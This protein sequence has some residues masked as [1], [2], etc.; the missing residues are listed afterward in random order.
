M[1]KHW[2]AAV[3]TC[4]FTLGSM[5]QTSAGGSASGNASVTPGQTGASANAS[6][7]AQT[8][9]AS[10]NADASANAQAAHEK[11]AGKQGKKDKSSTSAAGS[12]SGSATAVAGDSSALL[13]SGSTLQAEL[14]KSVDAKKAKSG[15][16]VTA[17]LTQD[18]KSNGQVVLH[19]GSKLVGHVTEAQAK[20]KDNAESK[21][22]IVFDKAVGKGSQE[23]AFNGVIQALAPPAQG[24]LSVAGD[25]SGNLGGGMGSNSGGM[26]SGH[27]GGG[28]PL[29]GAAGGV[30]STAGSA[31]GTVNNTAGS[32]TN[33]TTGAVNGSVNNTLGAA[34]NG[35]INSASHGVV[36]LQGLALDTAAAGNA[37]GSVI[38]STSRNVK[39][40]TGTQ[41][42]LQVTGSAAA[43]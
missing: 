1:K 24:A 21:L 41:L 35:T 31:L 2:I 11:Q 14:T 32:V 10:A 13:S 40:D 5:A 33:S 25:E 18:V 6:Q 7:S 3:V 20:S 26:G 34:A 37:Q 36:G 29:G 8:S 38:S 23:V 19:K 15:D 42:V 16:E 30:S 43:Q 28:S 4:M 17:R 22:G 9:G 39:L 12:G 27:S